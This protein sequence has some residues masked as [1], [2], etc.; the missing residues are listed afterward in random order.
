MVIIGVMP[1]LYKDPTTIW[2]LVKVYIKGQISRKDFN[3]WI[4]RS[5]KLKQI[6]DKEL[7][8]L[9]N[10]SFTQRWIQTYGKPIIEKAFQE[11]LNMSVTPRITLQVDKSAFAK[12]LKKEEIKGTILDPEVAKR[13]K[14][15]AAI[16]KANLDARYTFDTFIVGPSN[17]M[18]YASAVAVAENP[19][20]AYNPLFIYGPTGTGKTHLLQAIG[21]KVLRK[22]PNKR[23]LYVTSETF[24]NELV[25]A[26]RNKRTHLFKEKYRNMDVLI[27][28]DIQFVSGWQS[29]QDELFHTFNALYHAKKQIVFASDRP[30]SQIKDI[31]DRLRSRFEGGMVLDILPPDYETRFAILLKLNDQNNNILSEPVLKTIAEHITFNIRKLIGAYNKV[32]NYAQVL[33][34]SVTV[35]DVFIILKHEIASEKIRS[36]DSKQILSVIAQEFDVKKHDLLSSKRDATT[37]LARQVAMYILRTQFNYTLKQTAST[38]RRKDHTTVMHAVKKIQD[39]MQKSKA[40]KAKIMGLINKLKVG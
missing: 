4:V 21:H 12:P 25:D 7:V 2:N 31:A 11:V 1:A 19:G 28:D 39:K 38:L 29:T 32:K 30:P 14:L 20:V 10:N 5:T 23:V 26:L 40:F 22:D 15:L 27:I 17:Q 16:K 33:G 6:T 37:A 8:L 34:K 36:K 9:V 3:A 35:D 13:N 24:L 18:A